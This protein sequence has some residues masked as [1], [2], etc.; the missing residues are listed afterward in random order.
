MPCFMRKNGISEFDRG[1]QKI[2]KITKIT[3]PPAMDF[4][5]LVSEV[6]Q[7]RVR[8]WNLESHPG[9]SGRSR[10]RFSM[11]ADRGVWPHEALPVG[12]TY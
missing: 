12:E 2:K 7:G 11:A 6:P 9:L 10:S 3:I 1:F 4:H 5:E 8:S